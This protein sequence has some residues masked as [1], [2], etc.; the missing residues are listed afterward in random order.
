MTRLALAATV[1]V[2]LPRGPCACHHRGVQFTYR[3]TGRGWAEADIHHGKQSAQLSASYLTDSLGDLL[4]EVN[5]M[6]AG[7][8]KAA[9]Y[10]AKEPGGYRWVFT[11][12]DDQ[13]RL[14]IFEFEEAEDDS[15][16]V[17]DAT[18]AAMELGRAVAVGAQAVLTRYGAQ[19]YNTRWVE[20]PFPGGA[21][22]EFQGRL[23]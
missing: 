16:T 21:L 4:L 20:H 22:R 18:V 6:L 2:A 17:F 10:W 11:R 23:Q 19:N 8:N 13:V 14:R 12:E 3:L 1:V 5:R 9:C 15:A 7:A